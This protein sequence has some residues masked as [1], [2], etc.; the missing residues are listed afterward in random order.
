MCEF[1][2]FT[3]KA[4]L[5]CEATKPGLRMVCDPLNGSDCALRDR[6][7]NLL[8]KTRARLEAD[9]VL[10]LLAFNRVRRTSTSPMISRHS[11]IE[12]LSPITPFGMGFAGH[13]HTIF[14]A[15]FVR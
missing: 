3:A 4:E 15:D 5:I 8:C 6:R 11:T 12:E 9:D 2:G 10:V 1:K 13:Q 14:R 7:V